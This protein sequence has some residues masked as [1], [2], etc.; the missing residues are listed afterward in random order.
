MIGQAYHGRL[1]ED[2][3]G[4]AED[5]VQSQPRA[6]RRFPQ[7]AQRAGVRR[8]SSRLLVPACTM[9]QP[10]T[11]AAIAGIV[12]WLVSWIMLVMVPPR[13]RGGIGWTAD[14]L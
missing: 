4:C 12:C 2:E 13:L 6:A 1:F 10:A 3:R 7:A 11:T 8:A 5:A 14:L 9:S